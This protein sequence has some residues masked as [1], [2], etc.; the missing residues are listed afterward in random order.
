MVSN[1]TIEHKLKVPKTLKGDIKTNIKHT[2]KN[3]SGDS[4]LE[5]IIHLPFLIFGASALLR[6]NSRQSCQGWLEEAGGSQG[7]AYQR[8]TALNSGEKLSLP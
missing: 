5:K 7:A 4:G 2:K 3:S 6:M 1:F 8:E